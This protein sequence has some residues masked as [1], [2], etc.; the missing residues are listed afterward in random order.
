MRGAGE[1]RDGSAR[2][3]FADVTDR[4]HARGFEFGSGHVRG[5]P[6]SGSFLSFE[7]PADS[8]LLWATVD[9]NPVTPLRSNSGE[10]SIALDDSRQAHISLIWQTSPGRSRRGSSWHSRDS[11]GR[12]RDDHEPGH[13]SCSCSILTWRGRPA[14]CRPT[15]I[16]RLEM[17]RADWLLRSINDFV[18]GSIAA[19]TAITRNW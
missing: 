13:C 2:V 6:G 17:A 11:Q 10:W 16:A 9:S 12:T 8:T 4:G 19:P 3:G 5:G 1:S 14:A 18:Q 7:L 15:S